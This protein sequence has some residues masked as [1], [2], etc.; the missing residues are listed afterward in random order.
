MLSGA[1]SGMIGWREVARTSCERDGRTASLS[2]Y[3]NL[4]VSDSYLTVIAAIT[5]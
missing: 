2:E 4:N 1:K 5:T 3:Q